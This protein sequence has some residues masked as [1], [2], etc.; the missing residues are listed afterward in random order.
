MRVGLRAIA[1]SSQLEL[2]SMVQR[3][4]VGRANDDALGPGGGDD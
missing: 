4:G 3:C 2:A 1:T